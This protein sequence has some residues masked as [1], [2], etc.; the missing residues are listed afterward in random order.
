MRRATAVTT[1]V[2]ALTM[3]S[4]AGGPPKDITAAT[5]LALQ[6]WV[7]AVRTHTPGSP[8][9][10]VVTVSALS[11]KTRE[12][13][14]AGMGLFLTVL[15]A[16]QYD[17]GNNEAARIVADIGRVAR[18][19]P[20]AAA[21]LKQAV[22]LHSDAAAYGDL[23]HVQ[24]SGPAEVSAHRSRE[25]E[26][27]PGSGM[28]TNIRRDDAP[29]PPLLTNN[30]IILDKDGQIVGQ[31]AANWNWAF[32]RSL[33]DLLS[34]APGS[35]GPAFGSPAEVAVAAAPPRFVSNPFQGAWYHATTAYMLANGLYGEAT[36]HL[37][38]A[39]DVLPNDARILFDR[40]C[41]AEI[42]G[43]PM[44][45]AL[46]SE[47][48]VVLQRGLRNGPPTWTT[49]RSSPELRIPAAEKTNAEAERLFRRALE[50]DPS[51][52]EA[53]VRLAR[54]LDLRGRHEEAAAELNTALAAKPTGVVAFY[55]HLFA[56]RAAQALGRN[57]AAALHDHDAVMLFPDAQSA[58]LAGSQAALFASDVP[59][60]LA[61]LDH[62]G[63]HTSVYGADPW[64]DY[65]LGSGRDVNALMRGVW[66]MVPR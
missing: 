10:S 65:A 6:A 46:L 20:T 61:P 39:A 64:W 55:A 23:Y 47:A 53:R 37:Q 36:T 43:L 3:V 66:A 9:A 25:L 15:F 48:D 62:L 54:L 21:F 17:T 4:S 57:D 38:R 30:R 18:G 28:P 59:A 60:A 8:D 26:T 12:D 16:K 1:L 32:A 29:V 11:Y 49:P 27:D 58:L 42:L 13:M 50:A 2:L 5:A 56:G 31:V 7:D 41:Y 24:P 14:N 40:A 22:V 44:H 45:Q 33:L 51:F 63:D 52:V 19:N 35:A 34:Q